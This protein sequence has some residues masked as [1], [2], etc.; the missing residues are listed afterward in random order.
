MNKLLFGLAFLLGAL[1]IVAMSWVFLGNDTLALL[2]TL[3]IGLVYSIGTLELLR[4]QKATQ[5]LCLALGNIPSLST[6]AV[7][8][9]PEDTLAKWLSS[10]HA[11]LRN[12]VQLRIEGERIG[13]P[14]P[15]ITPYLVGL[16][17][18]LGLLGT[19]V[20]MVDTLQ[21]AVTA[22]QGTTEL[23]AIRAGLAA[24]INGLGLAFGTSV[25][26]VAAS[27]M[28]GLMST[29]S[30]RERVIAT[31]ELDACIAHEFKGFSLVHNRQETYKALQAQAQALPK[32]AEQLQ[33]MAL[34]LEHMGTNL[35]EQLNQKQDNFHGEVKENYENLADKV[36]EALTKSVS[37]VQEALSD[38]GRIAGE[39]MRPV[40][41]ESMGQLVEQVTEQAQQSHRRFSK[42]A[43]EHL[44]SLNSRFSNTTEEVSGIWR[45]ALNE[46]QESNQQSAALI[47]QAFNDYSEQFEQKT[48][49][50][51]D[52]L[53]QAM[54]QRDAQN[55]QS[56]E[57]RQEVWHKTLQE[58]Q[59]QSTESLQITSTV[60]ADKLNQVAEGQQ[61]VSIKV[62]NSFAQMTDTLSELSKDMSLDWQSRA[63]QM[64]ARQ[65]ELIEQ[66]SASQIRLDEQTK[67]QS[68]KLLAELAAL[69]AESNKLLAARQEAESTWLDEVDS[70]MS[71]LTVNIGDELSALRD[72]EA[73]RSSLTSE[74]MSSLQK[75]LSEQV[76]S[77]ALTIEKPMTDL[78]ETA[79]ETPRVAAEVISKLR[80]ELSNNMA[81]DNHL[82]EERQ[83]IMTE[84]DGLSDSLSQS[85]SQQREAIA[86]LVE[87]SS[88]MLDKI[89]TRFDQHIDTEVSKLSDIVLE[90]AASTTDIASLGDAFG[91]S[92]R[93]FSESNE[94]L[95]ESLKRIESSLAQSSERS[96][97]QLGYYVAQARE[98]IDH[99]VL[100]QKALFEEL[101]ELSLQ[102]A[103]KQASAE[104][105]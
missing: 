46:Q 75:N 33:A 10:L 88:G 77:L 66:L 15:V 72:D 86:S 101:R 30:R 13:L 11:S 24:P 22:L 34:K 40:L 82:L 39:S 63:D 19:F 52:S 29:L 74:A 73:A 43:S 4:F 58:V 100:S 99:S 80:E 50:M 51:L 31:R 67:Q 35:G 2:I 9:S 59:E 96:N 48:Q 27:A 41:E 85:S 1:A 26:G 6:D 12:S 7:E 37:V 62:A 38:S 69:F 21:G 53:N 64:L 79:S 89:S 65:N 104:P 68:E 105:V 84:L 18:M 8:L 3:V 57:A 36:S 49:A 61:E 76:A 97:E 93:L 102:Q 20:G 92:C 56:D 71:Q 54:V 5:T 95:G 45:E 94:R 16:L 23:E 55:R 81:R 90:A 28:L 87:S 98:V 83:R 14:A 91:K 60:V 42:Q 47:K 78:I 32:V 70:R 44:H 17:V 103:Y 25:A